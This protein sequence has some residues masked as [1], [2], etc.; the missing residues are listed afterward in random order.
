MKIGRGKLTLRLLYC[1]LVIGSGCKSSSPNLV[2]NPSGTSGENQHSQLDMVPERALILPKGA[3][4][5]LFRLRDSF[6]A[7]VAK[8][9]RG[10]VLSMNELGVLY[11]RCG[12]FDAA[13]YWLG[14][15]MALGNPAAQLELVK[16]YLEGNANRNEALGLKLLDELVGRGHEQA[17]R[18]KHFREY[19]M[20]L[21]KLKS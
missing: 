19:L 12:K 5:H 3:N 8:A 2:R 9:R 4:S 21:R 13:H 20:G 1:A 6:P 11:L 10:D 17:I 15:S 16:V 7:T 18:Y 14:R